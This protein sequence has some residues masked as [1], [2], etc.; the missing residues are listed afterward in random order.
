MVSAS[1]LP[2]YTN[3]SAMQMAQAIFGNGTTVTGA[4][5]TGDNRSSG[6]YTDGDNTS[7]N[8]TP[9][10]Y[11][12][13][14]STGRARDYTNNRGTA[15][16]RTDEGTNTGGV[17]NDAGFNAIAGTN[18]YD[19]AYLD[20]DFIPTGSRMTMEFTFASEEYPEYTL[21][22][23]QDM[24]GI[25]V[26]GSYVPF[27]AGTGD[28]DPN[29]INLNT[30]ENLFI[31]NSGS[32][33]NTEMDG[34]T[35]TLKLTFNVDPGTLNSI[36]I[37]IADVSD[38]RYDS[39]LLIAGDS[40]RTDL[41]A[42][43]D[44]VWV[45]ASGSKTADILA[46]DSN[47][48]GSTLTITHLNGQPVSAGD[49]ITL[50][51]GQTVTLNA[52]GTITATGNGQQE[53][54][55][56]TYTVQN[57]AGDTTTGLVTLDSV[58]C[59]VAGSLILTPAGPRPV[60]QLRIGDLVTTLDHGPQPIR[61]I[62]SRNAPAQDET[63]PIRIAAGTFGTHERLMVSPQHNILLR[64]FM[65]EMLFG[66]PECFVAAKDLLNGHSV[67]RHVGGTVNYHHLLL[68][69][70]EVIFSEGLATESFLPGPQTIKL[71][72]AEDIAEICA[73]LPEFDTET[74]AGYGPAARRVLKSFEARALLDGIAR[75]PVPLPDTA[76]AVA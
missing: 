56:F 55:I 72:S 12:V 41:I 36:R 50:P 48:S 40:L 45:S 69:R 16:Q 20:V 47:T 54:D 26:N 57:A 37:G 31:D 63:A 34:V 22:Q 59:F 67:R 8:A 24:I 7:P 74:G 70:H 23:Y 9:G 15:N 76:G 73:L 53:K 75:V 28:V 3:V 5:Y 32:A 38:D 11:G 18:T 21:S 58:P 13:I 51:S 29:N 6:I 42:E 66:V 68:D 30:N 10:D 52:D 19:A 65:A 1:K 71:F 43:D 64:D 2:V 44:Q 17:D 61:W 39:N 49:T 27:S 60:E 35:L 46:N 25:W 62:G 33:I 14:L 4:S